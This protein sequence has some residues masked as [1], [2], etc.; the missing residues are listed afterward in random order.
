[1]YCLTNEILWNC[2]EKIPQQLDTI[3]RLCVI[4]IVYILTYIIEGGSDY[5]N[6]KDF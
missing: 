5:E 6:G 2:Q 3:D 4:D 1:M